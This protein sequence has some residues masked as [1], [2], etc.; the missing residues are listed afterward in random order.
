MKRRIT[1]EEAMQI[2]ASLP[3]SL[4]LD[5]RGKP[6]MSRSDWEQLPRWR[7]L[8]DVLTFIQPP[9]GFGERPDPPKLD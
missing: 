6:L 9:K 2:G 5:R 1:L 8:L 4:W 7:R 3:V